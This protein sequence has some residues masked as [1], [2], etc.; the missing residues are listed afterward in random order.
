M[1]G[2]NYETRAYDYELYKMGAN[3]SAIR[4]NREH[5]YWRVY[6]VI[7]LTSFGLSRLLLCTNI[8]A[9]G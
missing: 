8:H 4:V 6:T 9:A 3:Q 5:V 1:A 7:R 2:K